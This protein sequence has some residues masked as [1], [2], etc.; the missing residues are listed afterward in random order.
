[1]NFFDLPNDII[2]HIYEFDSTYKDIFNLIIKEINLF[3]KFH[4]YDEI[5]GSY[6]FAITP[7]K[8]VY[9]YST[10]NSSN[11]KKAFKKALKKKV[12]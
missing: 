7:C 3:P 6:F 8:G 1:M 12:V 10:I 2:K 9:I 11:Y 5:F 4:F